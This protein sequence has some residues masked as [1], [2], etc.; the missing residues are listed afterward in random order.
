MANSAIRRIPTPQITR[1]G[2]LVGD[3]S[4]H[5]VAVFRRMF[6]PWTTITEVALH[7]ALDERRN[8]ARGARGQCKR[9]PDRFPEIP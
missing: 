4:P 9:R 1:D 5:T 3:R 6:P 8:E 7:P 2:A